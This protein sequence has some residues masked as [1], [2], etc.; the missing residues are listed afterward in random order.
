MTKEIIALKNLY[1]HTKKEFRN[2]KTDYI[3]SEL[4]LLDITLQSIKQ[5]FDRLLEVIPKDI[6]IYFDDRL[7][8]RLE[9]TFFYDTKDSKNNTIS[10]V[11]LEDKYAFNE[12]SVLDRKYEGL[13]FGYGDE[14]T[15]FIQTD[16]LEYLIS[17]WVE[18]KKAVM[19]QTTSEL[20]TMLKEQ[21]DMLCQKIQFLETLEN[22]RV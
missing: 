21:I 17:N 19:Q 4:E 14:I 10:I 5:Y 18:I 3:D 12:H 15:T 7:Q 13:C 22:W 11:L 6:A 8:I 20:K 1:T 16:T 2:I 9:K